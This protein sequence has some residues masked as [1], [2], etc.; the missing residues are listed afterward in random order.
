MWL[1][2]LL[3]FLLVLCTVLLVFA[4]ILQNSKGG[5]LVSS[6]RGASEASA[7]LGARR[8]ADVVERATW[9]LSGTLVVL[10][11]AINVLYAY[12]AGQAGDTD[13]TNQELE[14]VQQPTGTPTVPGQAPPAN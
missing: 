3:V 11:F 9:W 14:N 10:T 1:I 6:M 8:A 13:A 7:L 12:R 5:G 2:Y 4:I